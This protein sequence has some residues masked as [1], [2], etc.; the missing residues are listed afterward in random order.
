MRIGGKKLEMPSPQRLYEGYTAEELAT[1][2]TALKLEMTDG[3]FTSLGGASKSSSIQRVPIADR[4]KALRLEMRILGLADPRP[5][6]VQ[7][8][9]E[10]SNFDEGGIIT[11]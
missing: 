6:K 8:R 4:L 2:F 5:Q 1:E 11:Q 7:S 10:E 9:F 3:T